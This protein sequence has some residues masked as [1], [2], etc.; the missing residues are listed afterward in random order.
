M[1]IL[2]LTPISHIHGCKGILESIG[3]VLYM[4]NPVYSQACNS[5]RNIDTIF[6]N[7]NKLG[8]RIDSNLLQHSSVKI[9]CT[10]STGLDHID[11]DY[12]KSH[13]ITVLS[14]TKDF[15]ILNKVSSTAEHALALM[16]SLIRNIP[17][18]FDSVKNG[19]WDYV[20][21][22]GRQLDH[23]KVGIVGHGRLGKMFEKYCS[24]IGMTT[25]ICDPYKNPSGPSL[26]YIC[27]HSDVLSVHVH[28]N[29]TTKYII[30]NE[31][32]N[33]M[34]P[35]M[36]IINTSRGDIVDEYAIM[37]GLESGQING[38]ATDVLSDELE[39][40][41]QSP[42]IPAC[43]YYNIIIT[44]HIGGMTKEAQEMVYCHMANKLK[45]FGERT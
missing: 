18:S 24:A 2:C 44:P 17:R 22:I 25:L 31:I 27:Q 6:V 11:V 43:D 19:K 37:A 30:N 32:I 26:E 28:L 45:Q 16:L 39:D 4:D 14:A 5:A 40:S 10:A 29:D 21:F 38:Y 34:K 41:R 1:R 12:C 15:T 7:P 23:L 42:L 35:G 8:L 20:P 13:K 3:D 36:F 33:K 9:I